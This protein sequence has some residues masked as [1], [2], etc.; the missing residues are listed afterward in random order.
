M[1]QRGGPLQNF[2]ENTPGFGIAGALILSDGRPKRSRSV[3]NA[4]SEN[5][6]NSRL[7]LI[8]SRGASPMNT[9]R[10]KTVDCLDIRFPVTR[11]RRR[12]AV[13]VLRLHSSPAKR[14]VSRI[15]MR[16]VAATFPE[17]GLCDS[18]HATWRKPSLRAIA[19][20]IKYP[21]PPLGPVFSLAG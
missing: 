16:G 17:I 2:S 10:D 20:R 6:S 18:R 15:A 8:T 21:L 5:H 7:G 3:F 11:G 9:L 14:S 13:L 12:S 4:L 1:L 19:P